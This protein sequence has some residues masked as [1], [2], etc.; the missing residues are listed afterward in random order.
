M[1]LAVPAKVI[2]ITVPDEIAEVETLG[3]KRQAIISVV[4]GKVQP[5]DYVL[6]HAGF[7]IRKINT[8]E[9]EKTIELHKQLALSAKQM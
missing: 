2:E 3:I 7:A 5:G 4:D 9:A 8:A 1:C 6:I